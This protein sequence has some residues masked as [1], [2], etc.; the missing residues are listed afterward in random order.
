MRTG[1][2][3]L[4]SRI[5]LTGPLY[6]GG[7]CQVTQPQGYWRPESIELPGLLDLASDAADKI[8]AA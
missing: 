7:P 5:G 6:S 8:S 1:C 3:R 4:D 2:G